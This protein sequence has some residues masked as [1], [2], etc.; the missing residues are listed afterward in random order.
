MNSLNT[1]SS[2]FIKS[3]DYNRNLIFSILSVTIF[4]IKKEEIMKWHFINAVWGKKYVETYLDICLPFQLTKE[5]LL[6]VKNKA[7]IT[8]K[9]FTHKEDVKII[10]TSVFYKKLA[11][12]VNVKIISDEFDKKLRHEK[13]N[14]FHNIAIEE[15]NK[16]D[17]ALTFLFP[18]ILMSKDSLKN[19]FSYIEKGKKYIAVLPLRINKEKF[20]PLF[21]KQFKINNYSYELSSKELLEFCLPKLHPYSKNMIW[22]RNCDNISSWPAY[23][24]WMIKDKAIVA[25]CFHIHPFFVWPEKKEIRL[26]HTCD[27]SYP[28]EVCPDKSSWEIIKSAKDLAI[29]D[30]TSKS[31]ICIPTMKKN[32]HV[33]FNWMN[34][35]YLLKEHIENF[36]TKIIY[37][38]I[39]DKKELT[40]L[41]NE[42]DKLAKK[43][44]QLGSNPTFWDKFLIKYYKNFHLIPYGFKPSSFKKRFLHFF[45]LRFLSASKKELIKK[46]ITK[47]NKILPIK[48]NPN[49]S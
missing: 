35:K 46:I 37:S 25:R 4:V 19:L 38:L 41:E 42:S 22:N 18:D 5:N 1:Y 44:L 28:Y 29:F 11:E 31:E 48:I 33:L 12:I 21:K 30:I 27:F 2:I 20:I 14:Q 32:A 45:I 40:S 16:E 23:L 47:I 6:Y 7:D 10:E 26:N 8:Y 15:A 9:I 3:L 17:A 36:E 24:Y 34:D 39:D 49:V 13:M 43:I